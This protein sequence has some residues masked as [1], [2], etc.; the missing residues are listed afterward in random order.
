MKRTPLQIIALLFAFLLTACG[1]KQ[2]T[3][4]VSPDAPDT[5][6][7]PTASTQTLQPEQ[8]TIIFTNAE[9]A[10]VAQNDASKTPSIEQDILFKDPEK[11]LALV[12]TA[13]EA[14]KASPENTVTLLAI[15]SMLYSQLGRNDDAFEDITN[16]LR[17]KANP[18]LYAIR[19]ITLWR[20]GKFRGAILD[21]D[22][23]LKKQKNL[24][25]AHMAKGLGL[26]GNDQKT[27]SCDW[28]EE[29]CEAGFCY[30][31]EYVKKEGSCL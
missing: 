6:S 23:A 28:L 31:L 30:G 18:K 12:N 15:R 11:N 3:S 27:E 4:M 22:Y 8:T 21:A 7:A 25:M 14:E 20:S 19:S 1:S 17:Q 10:L 13:L 16:A 24:P 29:A 26:F 9:L 5:S 2:D